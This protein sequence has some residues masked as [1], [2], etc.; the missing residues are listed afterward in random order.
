MPSTNLFW[1]SLRPAE[2]FYT[3]QVETPEPMPV[4]TFLP[5]GYEPNYAYPLLVFFHGHG[6]SDE[7][8]LHLAPRL[9]RRNYVCIALRGPHRLPAAKDGRPAYSWG[10]DGQ[11][12]SA[13]EDYVLSAIE[14][15]RR[16]YHIHSERLFL[17]GVCEGAALAYRMGLTFPERFA[18]VISLNG[19]M[20]GPG[21]PL[22]R[23]PLVRQLR[24]FIGHGI[25]NAF[26]PLATA[27]AD[28][29]LLYTA[30]LAVRVRTYATTHRLHPDMLRDIN[31]WVMDLMNAQDQ[32][33]ILA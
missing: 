11:F 7:Q 3:S 4:R 25:A 15:T 23:L 14:A 13:A 19:T 22:L 18:G 21:G 2:G 31:R 17:A 8:V 1:R 33:A 5:T 9:S 26:V 29:R 16:N 32:T 20:G 6:S 30:G 10:L 24:V 27:R 12:D 28:F